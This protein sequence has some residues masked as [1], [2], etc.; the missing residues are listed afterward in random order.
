MWSTYMREPETAGVNQRYGGLGIG[1]EGQAL[2]NVVS[3]GAKTALEAPSTRNSDGAM[4]HLWGPG[5]A[6]HGGPR[7]EGAG[8]TSQELAGIGV[9]AIWGVGDVSP[10]DSYVVRSARARYC[11][12]PLAHFFARPPLARWAVVPADTR[13][14]AE[15][16]IMVLSQPLA[17]PM[18]LHTRGVQTIEHSDG[19]RSPNLPDLHMCGATR[20]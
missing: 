16:L 7:P 2:R 5:S 11:L 9:S 18:W 1:K 12:M 20:R 3:V 8:T 4:T 19:V 10:P 17:R 15:N 14:L 6:P 13:G